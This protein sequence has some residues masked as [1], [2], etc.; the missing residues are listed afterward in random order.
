MWLVPFLALLAASG[1]NALK[2][3][4]MKNCGKRAPGPFNSICI[5]LA[6][7]VI[8]ATV[9][10]FFWLG[11]GMGTTNGLGY[12][13]AVLGGLGNAVS[14][15]SWILASGFI[16]MSLI[17][18]FS[19]FG[20]LVAPMILAPYLFD[21]D[22]V[23]AL[24][25][26]GCALLVASVFTFIEP[27]RKRATGRSEVLDTVN[28]RENGR[29]SALYAIII[30]TLQTVSTGM[31]TVF[32]KY[33]NFHV[34]EKGNGT[35][36]YYNLISFC[37]VALAFAIGFAF[38]AL[39]RRESITDGGG[40]ISLPYRSVWAFILMAGVGLYVAQYGAGIA[41]QLPSAVYFPLYKSA[42]M[43]ETF[44]LDTVVFKDKFTLR[45]VLGLVLVVIA[46][47]LVNI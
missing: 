31:A 17:E 4:A 12:S 14:L 39:L 7:A 24:Q 1:G 19:T 32:Q 44:I 26:I 45:R 25:W 6:R 36:E 16:P 15:F 47:V 22:S 43:L 30:V 8:C 38:F 18:I 23:G 46:S 37:V 41:S 40:R 28:S 20:N 29:G 33:Y 27:A 42:I 9:S 3:Y 35:M 11:T 10:V 13:S 2:Q 5:N 21:G 34:A